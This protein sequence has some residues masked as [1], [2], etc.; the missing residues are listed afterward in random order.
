MKCRVFIKPDGSVL[1]TH[2]VWSLKRSDESDAQ[3]MDR[4]SQKL[5]HKNF[6]YED[7]DSE[8]L[9]PRRIDG[10]PVRD[11][12]RYKKGKGVKIDHSVVTIHDQID[13][14]E[15]AIDQELGKENPDPV[16]VISLRRQLEKLRK[17]NGRI[18]A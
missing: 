16:R 12:W 6:P 14:L 15:K 18:G 4:L 1:V 17:G 8:N 9:P 11:K 3:F 13:G 7:M 5:D 10:L 2:F